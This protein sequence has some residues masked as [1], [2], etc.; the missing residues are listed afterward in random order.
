MSRSTWSEDEQRLADVLQQE[1][2]EVTPH[3]DS[4]SAIA[5]RIG[6]PARIGDDDLAARRERRRHRAQGA[7]AALVASALVAATVVFALGGPLHRDPD[8]TAPTQPP[9]ASSTGFDP[10]RPRTTWTVYRAGTDRLYSDEV[11]AGE[12]YDPA[13]AFATLFDRPPTTSGP[14]GLEARGGNRVASVR[15]T[16]TAIVLDL[17]AA[18]TTSG[19]QDARTAALEAQAWVATARSAYNGSNLP[20]LVTLHGQ[21][22]RLFGVVDTTRPIA[23]D[24]GVRTTVTQRVFLPEAGA[25][26]TSPVDIVANPGRGEYDF[27]I[28]E[29]GTGRQVWSDSVDQQDDE[30]TLGFVAELPPGSYELVVKPGADRPAGAPRNLFQSSFTVT[31]DAPAPT[32]S[33]VTNPPTTEVGRVTLTWPERRGAALLQEW[34]ARGSVAQL[35]AD[36]GEGPERPSAPVL[37][38]WRGTSLDTAVIGTDRVVVDLRTAPTLEAPDAATA[39][40]WAASLV[41]GVDAVLQTD[42][43]VEVTVA[44]RPTRLFGQL[45]TSTTPLSGT[46]RVALDPQVDLFRPSEGHWGTGEA[47]VV[48]AGQA[49][50]PSVTWYVVD[51]V[52]NKTLYQGRAALDE[53]HTYG[54]RL[55][56]PAGDYLLQLHL[57]GGPESVTFYDLTVL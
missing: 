14:L 13:Q 10:T 4:W 18:D 54:F 7:A 34:R 49:G 8:P 22:F 24:D 48:G 37:L 30:G 16:P 5:A 15:W 25:R 36:L 55:P 29:E 46:L 6:D 28:R 12:P 19:R 9:T 32:S 1:G 31:G 57:D 53:Q 21:P 23:A 26:V 38:P 2:A 40:R 45:D 52:S 56:L 39:R 42:L 33:P 50:N 3:P 41:R 51:P 11:R 35:L 43:P 47:V 17:D 44:G 27:V 20:L